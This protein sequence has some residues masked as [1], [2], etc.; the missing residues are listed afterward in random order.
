MVSQKENCQWFHILWSFYMLLQLPYYFIWLLWAHINWNLLTSNSWTKLLEIGKNP[1]WS[2]FFIAT[3]WNIF[4]LFR[5]SEINRF[6]LDYEYN[7]GISEATQVVRHVPNYDYNLLGTRMQEVWP[8]ILKK[9][10]N[11]LYTSNKDESIYFLLVVPLSDHA[12]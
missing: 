11:V 2:T 12:I 1:S 5:V 8:E 3:L 7:N 4:V 9:I 6:L 10:W